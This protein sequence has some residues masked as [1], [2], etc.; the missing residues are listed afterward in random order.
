MEGNQK[1]VSSELKVVGHDAEF[2]FEGACPY[3]GGDLIYRID[4]GYE[5]T[6]NPGLWIPEVSS[7]C[8][9]SPDLD[10]DEFDEWLEAHSVMPYVHQLPVDQRIQKQIALEYRVADD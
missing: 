4:G 8:V 5:D 6:E 3:C 7:E 2:R 1:G 10:S 9:T